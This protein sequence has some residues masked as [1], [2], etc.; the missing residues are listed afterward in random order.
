MLPAARGMAD[1]FGDQV[2]HALP[3]VL[4]TDHAPC[5]MGSHYADLPAMPT[6]VLY[7]V[8]LCRTDRGGLTGAQTTMMLKMSSV[9]PKARERETLETLLR[10]ARLT[11]DATAKAFSLDIN[12]DL[13]KVRV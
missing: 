7:C 13:V 12:R 1:H 6:P 3:W 5:C 8:A 10:K 9:E 4:F 2:Q 11:E